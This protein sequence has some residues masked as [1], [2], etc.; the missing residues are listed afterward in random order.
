M[1][2]ELQDVCK[3]YVQGTLEV[4][5]L[6]HVTLQVGEGEYVAV[7]GPS[8]SGKSTLM[9]IVG[10]LDKATS[11][12]LLLD[13]EDV[14]KLSDDQ[15]SDIRLKKIGFIF[16]SFQ[17][18]PYESALENVA[19]PLT[20]AGVSKK[21]RRERAAEMLTRVGLADR[22]DFMPT[23]LSGGQKQRVAIARAMINHPK[24]LLADEP[25][26]ALDSASGRQVMDLFD[27]LNRE[28]VT[29]LMITHDRN[30]ASRAQR[31]LEI[32]DGRVGLPGELPEAPAENE[33]L[34]EE[35]ASVT[36]DLPDISAAAA[37]AEPDPEARDAALAEAD[38]A[39]EET[40]P[41]EESK[42]QAD[43]RE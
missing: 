37:E 42:E 33:E 5:A 25:T 24:I 30:I 23:Q 7:M 40:V 12:T 18:M 35:A 21:E 22:M 4:P 15:M 32:R 11:G 19:L 6:K 16:Q 13:G 2:L 10:C 17:L 29:I 39:A 43:E 8:G 36:E 9:N 27:E 38:A 3:N 26:G 28:G 20:Y 31:M 41:A 34:P 14:G 1:I